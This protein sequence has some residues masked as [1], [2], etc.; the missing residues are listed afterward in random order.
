[1]ERRD[2]A[3]AM[4]PQF[5]LDENFVEDRIC[6]VSIADPELRRIPVEPSPCPWRPSSIVMQKDS[7]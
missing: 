4:L 2:A 6:A 3:L 7:S 5:D 1:M